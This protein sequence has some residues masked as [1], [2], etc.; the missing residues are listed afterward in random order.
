MLATSS[1][2]KLTGVM[3]MALTNLDLLSKK[4]R[5]FVTKRVP[6]LELP[7]ERLR[8]YD[9]SADMKGNSPLK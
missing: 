7:S 1:I 2:L 5:L 8:P 3:V 9:A 4:M 6:L